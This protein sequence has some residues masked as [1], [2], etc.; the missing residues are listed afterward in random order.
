MQKKP[1]ICKE[2]VN[3]NGSRKSSYLYQT[4]TIL[5]SDENKTMIHACFS[6]ELSPAVLNMTIKT[7]ILSR[8]EASIELC[9]DHWLAMSPS[10]ET[11]LA[12]AQKAA[13]SRSSLQSLW[14]NVG[15]PKPSGGEVDKT[16]DKIQK[17]LE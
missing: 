1:V 7:V 17:Y 10:Q 15:A 16:L 2:R 3:Y 14:A 4:F 5:S 13:H 8:L 11:L 12:R 6:K 9:D